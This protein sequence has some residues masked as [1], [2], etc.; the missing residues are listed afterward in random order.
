[1]KTKTIRVKLQQTLGGS[2]R[3]EQMLN[4]VAISGQFI[5]AAT[6]GDYLTK[7]QAD[8]LCKDRHIEVTVNAIKA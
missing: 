5:E 2:Y 7:K 4:A 1:M 3:I 8:A 6:V